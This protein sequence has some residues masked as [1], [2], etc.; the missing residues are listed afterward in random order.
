[1]AVRTKLLTF[2]VAL[3]TSLAVVYT[4]PSGETPIIKWLSATNGSGSDATFDIGIRGPSNSPAERFRI[5]RRLV[6]A[7]T[8]I[9]MALW[10]VVPETYEIRARASAASAITLGLDGTE[11]EGVAD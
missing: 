7:N 5:W 2:P 6:P 1:L 4:A 10:W 8:D 3:T 9:Q 11:L